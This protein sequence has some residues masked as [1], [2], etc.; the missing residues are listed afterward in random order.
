MILQVSPAWA[1]GLQS[2]VDQPLQPYH[3]KPTVPTNDCKHRCQP[4][5]A[6]EQTA[7]REIMAATL[8]AELWQDFLFQNLDEIQ[9]PLPGDVVPSGHL[10]G[11]VPRLDFA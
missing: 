9:T 10:L 8:W 5:V 1:L 11:K 3:I 6:S 4:S 7:H 2:H